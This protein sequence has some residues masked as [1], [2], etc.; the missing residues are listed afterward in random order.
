M[1]EVRAALAST[2]AHKAAELGRVLEGW[3]IELLDG[4]YP[5]EDG[6]SFE[7]NALGKARFGRTIAPPDAWVLGEDS[8]IEVDALGGAPGIYSARWGGGDEPGTMLA[9]MAGKTDRRAR[10]VTALVAISPE[11]RE[12]L[13]R[14]TLEGRIAEAAA[15]DEGF[16]YDPVFIPDGEEETTAQLGAAW[17]AE[18]SHRTNAAL[19]LQAVLSL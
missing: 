4:D 5:P 7:E 8:G 3:R 6:E 16:G 15:G 9:A 12:L 18:H 13:V 14:G 10:F 2:N 11:G 17:K 1:A 19:A